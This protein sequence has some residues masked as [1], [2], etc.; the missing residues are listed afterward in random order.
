M[1]GH[2]SHWSPARL[3]V[4]AD[5]SLEARTGIALNAE[6]AHCMICGNPQMVADTQEVLKARGLKKHRRKEA[7]QITTEAY[8]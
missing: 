6:T 4:I 1:R 5:G 3:G 2:R 7:G 8:W